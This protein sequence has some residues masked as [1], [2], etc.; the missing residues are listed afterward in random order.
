M[1]WIKFDSLISNASR[2]SLYTICELVLFDGI[3][4]HDISQTLYLTGTSTFDVLC[5]IVLV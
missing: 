2:R 5:I 1:T 4:D 3:L